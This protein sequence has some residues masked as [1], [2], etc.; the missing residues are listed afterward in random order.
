[1]N[2]SA[3][4]SYVWYTDLNEPFTVASTN[5]LIIGDTATDFVK[6]FGIQDNSLVVFCERNIYTIYMPSQ[7]ASEWKLVK[8]RSSYSS[9]SPY[10]IFSYNNKVGFPAVQNDKFVGIAGLYG[11]SY[12][13]S[14]SNLDIGTAASELL[15]DR[16]EPDMFDVQ[17]SYIGNVSSFVFKNKAYITVTKGTGNT[18]NNRIYVMDFS[19]EN[20]SKQGRPAWA[21]WSGLNAAQFTV[22][23]GTLYFGSSTATG[24]VWKENPGV[25]ADDGSA[26][27]SYYWTKEFAGYDGEQSYQKDFRYLN[28]LVDLPGSY[29]MGVGYRTDSGS[30][31]GIVQQLSVDPRRA[32]CRG[33]PVPRGQRSGSFRHGYE[34]DSSK[35]LR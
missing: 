29:F 11:D 10:G 13:V 28:V 26:I 22:Y 33:L 15:S 16:I 19:I 35:Q 3:Q 5:F 12:D 20:M 31:S 21:R 27:D 34:E 9:K 17:S 18:T 30:G 2:D 4:P 23:S 1:M 6:G 7:T 25:Y 32:C 8:S 14:G 24:K